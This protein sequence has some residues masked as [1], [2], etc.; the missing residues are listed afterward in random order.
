MA[1]KVIKT[2]PEFIDD[3][4]YISRVIN[5]SKLP[6]KSILFITRKAGAITAN[7]Y[8]KTDAHYIYC[9]TGK[10]RYFEKDMRKKNAR[11][12]SV[13]LEPGDLVLSLPMIAHATE[14]LE[15]TTFLAF[16]SENRDQ[17]AYEE[18]TVRIK[19]V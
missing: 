1:I 2:N 18:D 6:I 15:D 16:A 17:K 11:V 8:H 14:F 9:L 19:I 13:I 3:R 7:H 12:T 4:G 5:D 10:I